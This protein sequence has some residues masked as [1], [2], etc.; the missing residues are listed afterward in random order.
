MITIK[1][2]G[3]NYNVFYNGDKNN[4][5]TFFNFMMGIDN[6]RRLSRGKAG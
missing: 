2:Y 5:H 6:A 1:D 3:H 4:Y